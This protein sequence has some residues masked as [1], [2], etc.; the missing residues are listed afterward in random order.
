MIGKLESAVLND[1]LKQLFPEYGRRQG[2]AAELFQVRRR[3]LDVVEQE[4][5]GFEDFRQKH[6]RN[7][8]GIANPVKLALCGEV[9]SEADSVESTDQFAVLPGLDA[10]CHTH[11]VKPNV[12]V[13]N[14][15]GD[16]GL[17]AFRA[18]SHHLFEFRVDSDLE[19]SLPDESL[20]IFRNVKSD[21]RD[22]S[23][24]FGSPPRDAAGLIRHRKEAV[25]VSL[26]DCLWPKYERIQRDLFSD[27]CTSRDA[28]KYQTGGMSDNSSKHVFFRAER[29]RAAVAQE[30]VVI[31]PEGSS[32]S[33]ER[34]SGS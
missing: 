12:D 9:A 6:E 27:F 2:G 23:T 3:I 1:C 15:V 32:D 28:R 11:F 20:Q 18:A 16:P 10:S 33:I 5:A 22:D 31:L 19:L 30:A 34:P 4:A 26:D 13:D 14:L 7:F 17:V 21:D 29:Q 24:H 25:E 8:S